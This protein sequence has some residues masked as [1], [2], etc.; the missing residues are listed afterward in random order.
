MTGSDLSSVLFS[1]CIQAMPLSLIVYLVTWKI[2]ARRLR[3][4]W[5][6]HL[7]GV[8]VIAVTMATLRLG[9]YLLKGVDLM[10]MM[11]DHDR[12]PLIRLTP[13]WVTIALAWIVTTVLRRRATAGVV[14]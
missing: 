13:V 5:A 8:G 14:T 9:T 1:W 11:S 4:R 3:L 12:D 10:E 6:W 2:R 7:L